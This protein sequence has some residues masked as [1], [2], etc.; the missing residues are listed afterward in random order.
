MV[1]LAPS[2]AG[3]SA[4]ERVW[5]GHW[6]LEKASDYVREVRFGEQAGHAG[7]GTTAQVLAAVRNRLLMQFRSADW[8]SIA[9]A[10]AQYGASVA[11]VCALIGRDV[12]T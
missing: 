3:A 8:R 7:Q 10:L 1:S 2:E 11:R 12:K 6:R 5:R 9:D 4:L